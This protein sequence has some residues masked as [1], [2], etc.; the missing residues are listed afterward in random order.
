M[1][2]E[3]QVVAGGINERG[4]GPTGEQARWTDREFVSSSKRELSLTVVRG[5]GSPRVPRVGR[6]DEMA[7]LIGWEGL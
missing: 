4:S 2:G 1:N 3:G 7:R 6:R 5:L